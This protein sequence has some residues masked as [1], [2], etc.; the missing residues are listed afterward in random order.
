MGTQR[1]EATLEG[2][3]LALFGQWTLPLGE[4]WR[5][6]PGPRLEHSRVALSQRLR[7]GLATYWMTI[8]D[9]QVQQI[10]QPGI[11]HITN[12]A[13]ARSRGVELDL[14]Y[15][16]SAMRFAESLVDALATDGALPT[17]PQSG[18]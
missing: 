16:L 11:G 1:N 13:A 15:L 18:E 6:T 4:R 10:V 12:A 5:L 8:D 14:D 7:Y 17:E 3:N 2:Q 9:M